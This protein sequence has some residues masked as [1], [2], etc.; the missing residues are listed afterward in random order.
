MSVANG[1][2]IAV[3]GGQRAV[4]D[5]AMGDSVLASGSPLEWHQNT[6]AFS[7][8]TPPGGHQALVYMA[9]NEGEVLATQNHV[10]VL[11][12]FS[13]RRADQLTPGL[14]LLGADGGEVEVQSVSVGQFA[15]GVHAIATEA[16]WNPPSLAG[17]LLNT[18]GIVTGDY[19]LQLNYRGGDEAKIGTPEYGQPA[20]HTTLRNL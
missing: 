16:P 15:G 13:L 8:G 2:L 20:S 3:P 12:D 1:T 18:N 7:Q 4:E 17:R 11:L 9:W 14:I 10:F 19:M 6:V 5:I